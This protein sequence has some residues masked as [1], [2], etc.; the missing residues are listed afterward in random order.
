MCAPRLP[1]LLAAALVALLLAVPVPVRAMD[2]QALYQKIKGSV[3]VVYQMGGGGRP[4]ALGSGFAIGDGTLVATNHHMVG[5]ASGFVTVQTADGTTLRDIKVL[6]VSRENDLAVIKLPKALPPLELSPGAAGIGQE[7][8][9]LGNPEGL[10]GTLSTGVVS[11]IRSYPNWNVKEVLQITV[12]VSPGS[13]GSPLLDKH[14][15][16][17]GVVYAGYDD[18]QNMNFAVPVEKLRK[19]LG[20]DLVPAGGNASTAPADSAA[21]AV[22]GQSSGSLEVREGGDGSITIIQQRPKQ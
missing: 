4:I 13:S 8:A 7:V 6:R 3:V 16:V 14:G 2:A 12:P 1:R 9:A 11:G 21:P 5:G 18:V 22:Q 17:V 19:L 10:S 20:R 15:R